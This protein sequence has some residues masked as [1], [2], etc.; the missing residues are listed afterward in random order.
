MTRSIRAV[1]LAVSLCGISS[2]LIAQTAADNDTVR[3]LVA[4]QYRYFGDRQATAYGDLFLPNATFIT[5]DGLKMDGRAEIVDGNTVFFGMID[6]VKNHVTYKNLTINFLDANTAVTYT[7]WDGLWTK[8]AINNRAQSGYLT[9]IMHKV[10][11]RW[12]IASATNAFN[13]RG[14][15]DFDLTEYPAFRAQMIRMQAPPKN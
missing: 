11:N 5:V 15:P 6:T 12:L 8:P 4:D 7:V 13:Y 2:P 1:F 3:K 9:M 10:K 14:T